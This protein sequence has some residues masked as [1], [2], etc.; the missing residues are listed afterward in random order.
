MEH[1]NL[2]KITFLSIISM[3]I[4]IALLIWVVMFKCNLL[5][6]IRDTYFFFI[7]KPLNEKLE[8]Y[9]NG[10]KSA[11]TLSYLIEYPNDLLEDILNIIVFI[12]FGLYVSFFS[13]KQKLIKAIIFS[14]A[15]SLFLELFQFYTY[16]GSFAFLDIITNVFGGLIG[17]FIYY[18]LQKNVTEKKIMVLNK[19]T[20]II[21]IIMIPILLYAI[22]NTFINIDFYID[23]L[24]R[25]LEL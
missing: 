18:L 1:I 2:K 24:L 3:I 5:D 6:S 15:L 23:V 25:R 22:I 16:I 8:F 20:L 21:I 7:D 14:F 9:I 19:L 4:Y 11:F 10:F 13:K 12:P 17:Y